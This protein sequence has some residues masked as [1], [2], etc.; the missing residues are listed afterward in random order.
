MVS[1]KLHEWI[2]ADKSLPVAQTKTVDEVTKL[3]QNKWKPKEQPL[4]KSDEEVLHDEKV[5]WKETVDW[6]AKV[7]KFVE[8]QFFS[9]WLNAAVCVAKLSDWGKEKSVKI[10]NNKIHASASYRRTGKSYPPHLPH[11]SH[12]ALPHH[13]D[14]LL[15]LS[16][17]HLSHF[18][19]GVRFWWGRRCSSYVYGV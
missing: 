10:V 1:S 19:I 6:S 7:I 16:S 17:P 14:P 2:D 11:L 8:Q 12:L 13:L 3:V 15:L 9:S 5:S 4:E 18:K